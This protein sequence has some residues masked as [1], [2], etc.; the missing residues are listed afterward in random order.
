VEFQDLADLIRDAF[1][2]YGALTSLYERCLLSFTDFKDRLLPYDLHYKGL[3]ELLFSGKD[4]LIGFRV[5]WPNSHLSEFVRTDEGCDGRNLEF[6][7]D[8]SINFF[9]GIYAS[10][11]GTFSPLVEQDA[12]PNYPERPGTAAHPYWPDPLASY[13]LP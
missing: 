1:A 6:D 10:K 2:F 13:K 11:R 3:L 8:G 7:P 12:Q 5:Y 4:K 9:V